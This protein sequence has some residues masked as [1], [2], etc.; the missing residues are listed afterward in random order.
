MTLEFKPIRTQELHAT[1]TIFMLFG[2]F[3]SMK[4]IGKFFLRR[5]TSLK[6]IYAKN[7]KTYGK[8]KGKNEFK[9]N[10]RHKNKFENQFARLLNL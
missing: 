3:K 1:G 7:G 10:D 9:M 4:N 6:C 5:W 8:V 2:K